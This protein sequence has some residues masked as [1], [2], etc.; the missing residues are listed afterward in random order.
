[1]LSGNELEVMII[2]CWNARS[3]MRFHL[4]RVQ[5]QQLSPSQ[6][7]KISAPSGALWFKNHRGKS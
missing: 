1:M 4:G 3:P 6:K 2:R 5:S 7:S